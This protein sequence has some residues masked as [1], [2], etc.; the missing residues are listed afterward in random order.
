MYCLQRYYYYIQKGIKREMLA[1]QPTEQV[2]RIRTMIPDELLEAHDLTKLQDC[3]SDEVTQD[4]E[5]S[6]RKSIGECTGLMLLTLDR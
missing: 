2:K 1:P 4:Y 6:V 3:L 5:F